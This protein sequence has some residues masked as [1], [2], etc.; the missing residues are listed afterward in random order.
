MATI[1]KPYTFSA[2]A[3]AYAEHVNANFDT[4]H[5]ELNG[6]LDL[7]NLRAEQ[8]IWSA[9]FHHA[10]LIPASTV[11][12][13][14]ERK[15]AFTLPSITKEGGGSVEITLTEVGVAFNNT[16]GGA[17]PTGKARVHLYKYVDPNWVTMGVDV[18]ATAKFTPGVD[19]TFVVGSTALVANTTYALGVQSQVD[20]AESNAHDIDVW[21]EGK[22][23]LF[24]RHT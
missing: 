22:A 16:T 7:A 9:Q 8:F 13:G 14:A 11:G 3:Y 4:L 15:F 10:G 6:N 1:T 17:A 19:T 24:G 18:F 2:G 20:G 23:S 12:G 5:A 21:V